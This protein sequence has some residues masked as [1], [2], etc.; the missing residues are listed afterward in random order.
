MLPTL[1]RLLPPRTNVMHKTGT[2]SIGIAN[3][4]GIVSLPD[5]AGNVVFPDENLCS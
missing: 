5:G 1:R 2:L 4:V 3:D